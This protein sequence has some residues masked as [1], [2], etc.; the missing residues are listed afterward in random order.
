MTF[1]ILVKT[2]HGQE[3]LSLSEACIRTKGCNRII[4]TIIIII[5]IIIIYSINNNNNNDNDGWGALI[6]V[7]YQNSMTATCYG[8]EMVLSASMKV[9][10]Y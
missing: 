3:L 7:L 9:K 6:F 8:N 4:I 5:I 10:A 2:Y 1:T